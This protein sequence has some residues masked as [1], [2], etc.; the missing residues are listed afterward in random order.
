MVPNTTPLL[1]AIPRLHALEAEGVSVLLHHLF[2]KDLNDNEVEVSELVKL[3]SVEFPENELR[4]LRY[5]FCDRSPY[6]EWEEIIPQL[7]DLLKSH[8]RLKIQIS[9]GKEV[10]AACGQFLVAFPRPMRK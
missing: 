4:V 2:I 7:G 10:Q 1:D 8:R 3:L 5:N 9:A 6:R